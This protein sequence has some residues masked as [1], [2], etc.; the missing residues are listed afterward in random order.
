[1]TRKIFDAFS[2]EPK[3]FKCYL[4][5][6]FIFK[7]GKKSLISARAIFYANLKH[8]WKMRKNLNPFYITDDF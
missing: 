1:M 6:A 7:R 3:C 8:Q 5:S 4:V 2:C